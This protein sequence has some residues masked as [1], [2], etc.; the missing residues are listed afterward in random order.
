MGPGYP[1][2]KECEV[3]GRPLSTEARGSYREV[4]VASPGIGG[5]GAPG[6]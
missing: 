6:W 1:E 2:E 4:G 3:L 5:A